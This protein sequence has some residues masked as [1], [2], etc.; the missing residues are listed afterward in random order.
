MNGDVRRQ[1][2]LERGLAGLDAGHTCGQCC[3]DEYFFHNLV[4]ASGYQLTH[5]PP[6]NNGVNT[7]YVRTDD[8]NSKSRVP[9]AI[10]KRKK[11]EASFLAS[12]F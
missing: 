1:R 3:N 2:K 7:L 8:A 5:F 6:L 12:G 4:C 11:P 9:T 10:V